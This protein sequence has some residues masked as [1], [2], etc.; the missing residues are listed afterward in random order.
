[1]EKVKIFFYLDFLNN[2]FTAFYEKCLNLMFNWPE[3]QGFE[4]G[5]VQ[6]VYVLFQN[7]IAKNGNK[8]FY[9]N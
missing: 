8:A 9:R 1:M 2:K 5:N 6:A 3:K 7:K 4:R